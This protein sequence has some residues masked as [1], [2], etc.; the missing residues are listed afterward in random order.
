MTAP[1]RCP[2]CG[3]RLSDPEVEVQ[4]LRDWALQQGVAIL[5]NDLIHERDAARALGRSAGTLRNWRGQ[6]E[7]LPPIKIRGRVYYA[8]RDVAELLRGE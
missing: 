7:P 8:L 1:A 2:C 5:P 4:G 3:H 6:H